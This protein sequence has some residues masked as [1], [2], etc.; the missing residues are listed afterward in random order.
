MYLPFR[1][2]GCLGISVSMLILS[3]CS[4]PSE[5]DPTEPVHSTIA[6]QPTPLT[7]DQEDVKATVERFLFVAGNYDLED[8]DDMIL[9][10]ANIGICRIRE[11]A[12]QNSIITFEEYKANARNR[13][14]GPYYEPVR[15]WDI[16]VNEGQLAFVK[17]DAILHKFGV[18]TS[19][20][21]DYFTLLKEN[22]AW[23]FLNLSFTTKRLPEEEQVFDLELFA[24]S[25][26]Q[27]WSGRRPE[28]VAMFFE[29]NGT[30][31]V[32]DGEPATGRKE[33]SGIAQGFM[34]DLPDMEVRFDSL[35]QKPDQI[36][37]HW[38]LLATNTGPGGTGNPVNVSGYEEWT[39]GENGLIQK[40]QGHFPSEEYARQI[41]GGL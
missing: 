2:I 7:P 1:K 9:D 14:L 35:L 24:R 39:I 11:G 28:F 16:L 10:K 12:W 22:G 40:S 18:P 41:Q 20:N 23:Q 27:A 15:N 31:R 4:E 13:E 21:V 25:Y 36:Q 34:T 30:L 8:M 17:A 32:N 33:I 6:M 19:H 3:S 5:T 29:E 26:A 38:T 37:F